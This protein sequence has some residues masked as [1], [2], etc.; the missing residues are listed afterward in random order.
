[1]AAAMNGE[2]GEPRQERAAP[3]GRE[4]R[5]PR[6]G[7]RRDRNGRRN[8]RRGERTEGGAPE[9]APSEESAFNSEVAPLLS[10]EGQPQAGPTAEQGEEQRQPRER[11]SRD[12]YGRD[13][14]ERGEGGDR[15][16]RTDG[17]EQ[18][19]QG[20]A[21]AHNAEAPAAMHEE[22]KQPVAEI[23]APAVQ[24]AAPA[25]VPRAPEATPATAKTLP[26]VQ[27][28][29]LPMQDLVQVAETSGLQWVNSD[30]SKIAEAQ[31]AIASEPKPIHVPRE[32]APVV[33]SDD[34]PL[35]LVETKRDLGDM[36][37]PFENPAV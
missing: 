19:Q 17:G 20:E 28:Y 1:M 6:E 14:R 12:R 15:V 7:G 5:E 9:G 4:Q 30:A 21:P 27:S 33:V 3:E 11:R 13:R 29:A 10:A 16:E 2:A 32:R 25:P 18:P 26:K 37:L 23:A 31:A 35:V 8:D 36:K 24:A 22:R 34:G